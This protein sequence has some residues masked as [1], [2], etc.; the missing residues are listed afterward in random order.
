MNR[1]SY[2]DIKIG[3]SAE[4]SREITAE[5]MEQFRVMSGDDNPLHTDENFAKD[6]GF[7][8]KV[9]YGMLTASLYS[10]LG[11]GVHSRR[12]LSAPKRS[13]RFF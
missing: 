10:C 11:G 6:R 2:D 4:F 13:R 7:P 5:M 12:T 1:Y 8:G 9:V 3:Q